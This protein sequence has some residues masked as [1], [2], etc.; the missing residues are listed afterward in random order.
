MVRRKESRFGFVRAS[1]MILRGRR[2]SR[3]TS[4]DG[5]GILNDLSDGSA[6]PAHAKLGG[7]VVDAKIDRR[8]DKAS[9]IYYRG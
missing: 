2:N 1:C 3:L 9:D 6:V 4:L 7:P 5:F 8:Y